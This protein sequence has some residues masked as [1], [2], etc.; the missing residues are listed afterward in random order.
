MSTVYGKSYSSRLTPV[1]P[2]VI[3]YRCQ[4]WWAADSCWC[5]GMA[6]IQWTQSSSLLNPLQ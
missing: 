4:A 1:I 5:R 3:S 6:G 2:P